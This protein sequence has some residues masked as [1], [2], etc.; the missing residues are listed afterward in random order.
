MTKSNSVMTAT[1]ALILAIGS[2][3]VPAVADVERIFFQSDPRR[4]A[5]TRFQALSFQTKKPELISVCDAKEQGGK[6]VAQN[7]EQACDLLRESID[8]IRS[9]LRAALHDLRSHEK[10]MEVG[11]G[12]K[13]HL[14][15]DVIALADLS[16]PDAAV[17]ESLLPLLRALLHDEPYAKIHLLLSVAVFSEDETAAENMRVLLQGIQR[18]LNDKDQPGIPQVY[19]FDRYKEGVWEARDAAELQTIV[20]NFLL[21]LLSGGLAQQLAH[22]TSSLDVEEKQAYFCGASATALIF[23]VE[24]LQT[25]CAMRLGAEILEAE[26]RSNLIP[27]PVLIQEAAKDFGTAHANLQVWMNRL[28]CDSLFRVRGG[29]NIEIHFSDLCFEEAPMEDWSK[30]ILEYDAAFKTKKF[31]AQLDLIG[32]NAEE[33]RDEF[34][35]R[36]T[37]FAQ[38]LPGQARFYPGGVRASQMILEQVMKDMEELCVAPRDI[39]EIERDSNERIKASLKALD[40]SMQSLPK[41][42]RWMFRLPAFLRK[43]AVQLFNLIFLYHDLKTVT[44][45]RQNSVRLLE[46]KYEAWTKEVASGKLTALQDDWKN[47]LEKQKKSLKNLQSTLDRLQRQFAKR[48]VELTASPSMFR[49]SA[50]DE[51]VLAWAYYTGQRPPE[52]FRHALLHESGFLKDW[53]KSGIKVFESRLEDFCKSVYLRL[54]STDLEEALHHRNGKDAKFLALSMAQ[55]AVPLLRPNF[56]QTGS[57]ASFQLRFFQCND[58]FESSLYPVFKND[59]Q[60]WQILGSDD[61]LIATCCRVR[62]MIP[63]SALSHLFERG[64]RK[65]G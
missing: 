30:L 16:E 59:E 42:P 38:S 32:K 15:L 65:A 5:I 49:L 24:R 25:A 6:S 54:S 57:G 41:P 23:D 51:S 12:S 43:P 22:Q 27:D 47:A 37:Q 64:S 55:G 52:G 53:H 44:K 35:G 1:P 50:L 26:F 60:D 45:L 61:L 46:Q 20:G 33:L 40:Q 11:L 14:P 18:I 34:T 28:C 8:V 2:A 17:L 36:L 31:P 19:L 3:F 4:K 63:I 58:P 7:K 9:G 62:M 56:D 10:V 21:A 48:T 29:E 13:S 39:S